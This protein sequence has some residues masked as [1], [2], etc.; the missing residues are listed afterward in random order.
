M[1]WDYFLNAF[2]TLF[3]TIDPVAIA[4]IFIVLTDGLDAPT[5]RTMALRGAVTSWLILLGFALAG[6]PVLDFLGISQA[7]FRIA[8]GLL[9]FWTAVE[10]VFG[11]RYERRARQATGEDPAAI[12]LERMRAAIFPLAIPLVAGPGAISATILLASRSRSAVAFAG[13]L[14]I[15]TALIGLCFLVFLAAGRI[16]RFLGD[17]GRTVLTRLLGI[18][19]AALA[20]QFVLAGLAEFAATGAFLPAAAASA[21]G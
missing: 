20:V 4:P 2:A 8:G 21:P 3:V 18:I 7:A 19:L 15:I 11:G 13:L 12:R 6:R 9:L 17:T 1:P 14:L 16:D 5:R 10:M